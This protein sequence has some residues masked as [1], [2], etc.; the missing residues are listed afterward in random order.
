MANPCKKHNG[1]C[2]PK[3][4]DWWDED[5]A[6]TGPI[7]HTKHVKRVPRLEWFNPNDPETWLYWILR[8]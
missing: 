5:T 1:D 6:L 4:R 3:R 7:R 8:T 2:A